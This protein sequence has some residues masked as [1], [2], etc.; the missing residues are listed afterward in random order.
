MPCPAQDSIPPLSP[1]PSPLM[2]TH[3]TTAKHVTL[4]P[5]ALSQLPAFPSAPPLS[6]SRQDMRVSSATQ[7]PTSS[8]VS[9]V[10]RCASKHLTHTCMHACMLQYCSTSRKH[11][12]AVHPASCSCERAS[13]KG[14]GL[15]GRPGWAACRGGGWERLVYAVHITM[16]PP[17]R[18]ACTGNC[19]PPP[20]QFLVVTLP[21]SPSSLHHYALHALCPFPVLQT[22]RA[23]SQPALALRATTCSACIG[24]GILH[25]SACNKLKANADTLWWVHTTQV[26]QPGRPQQ[27]AGLVLARRA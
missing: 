9:G 1:S 17:P 5:S 8:M 20:P 3:R 25:Q 19:P 18:Q 16:R 13:R 12:T 21:A 23:S 27:G 7:R 10:A 24:E 26:Q 14:G 15:G 2:P 11:C 4:Q 22:K 6:L